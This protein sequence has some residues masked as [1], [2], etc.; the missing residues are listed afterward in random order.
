M[1]KT[2]IFG[3]LS[4]IAVT[5]FCAEPVIDPPAPA[6][7]R[8]GFPEAYQ[9]K[10]KVLRSVNRT[11]KQQVVTV[12]GNDLAASITRTNDLPY[13]NGSV[14]VMETADAKKDAASKPLLDEQGHYRKDKVVGLHVMRRGKDFGETYAKNRSGEWEY[15]EFRADKTYITPPQ[16]SF[17]CASCHIKAGP[18]KD[19]VYGGRFAAASK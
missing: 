13:P 8:V 5:V 7:D 11:E 19:F 4:A 18:E 3:I 16:K 12:Y 14:I 1:K 9:E 6:T 17:A 15:V 2:F 10:F